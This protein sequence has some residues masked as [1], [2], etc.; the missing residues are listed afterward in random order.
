MEIE[1]EA[2]LQEAE[3]LARVERF[4][5]RS[6]LAKAV[7]ESLGL[8]WSAAKWRGVWKDKQNVR[9]RIDS[10]LGNVHPIARE[11]GRTELLLT[12]NYRGSVTSDEHVPFHDARAIALAADVLN[13]WKPDVHIFNGDQNDFYALSDFDKNPARQH[14]VQEE[15]DQT[16][17][18]LYAPIRRAIPKA[19]LIKVDGNHCIRRER[20]LRRHP[21][22]AGLRAL[23]S[24]NLFEF[25]KFRIHYV[26]M[27]VR[28]GTVLEVTHGDRVSKWAGMSAKAEQEKRRFSIS[29]ITGHVHR[30][31]RFTTKVGD[32]WVQGVE[33]PCLCTLTPEWM[34][35]PD[36]A[37]GITLFEVHD[38]NLWIGSVTF[39]SNY[40]AYAA[41]KWFEGTT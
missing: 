34:I 21:E 26:P 39:G 17:D 36:W 25:D 41:G 1:L 35:D 4:P 8:E 15:A 16:K 5:S 19:T 13:F 10:A 9:A 2:V 28:F 18:E 38:G 29:T 32:K 22:L 37:L 31:G 30:S 27:R 23:R 40:T 33:N 3:R 6:V 24:E 11:D 7:N 12:G 20:W 14:T